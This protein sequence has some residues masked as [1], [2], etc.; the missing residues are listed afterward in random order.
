[1][2]PKPLLPLLQ[3]QTQPET[4]VFWLS[5]FVILFICGFPRLLLPDP[6]RSVLHL[7]ITD[8]VPALQETGLSRLALI[9]QVTTSDS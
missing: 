7:C 2:L 1:M 6:P 8:T 5:L 4:P 9:P 3:L